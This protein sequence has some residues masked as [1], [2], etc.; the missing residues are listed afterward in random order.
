MALHVKVKAGAIA[1]VIV[2]ALVTVLQAVDITS[3][4]APLATLVGVALTILAAYRK[5]DE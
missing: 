5:S 1:G 2:T 3:L 4:S